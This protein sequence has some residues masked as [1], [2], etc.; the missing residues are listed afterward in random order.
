MPGIPEE[1]VKTGSSSVVVVGFLLAGCAGMM[2]D[3]KEVDEKASDVV[4]SPGGEIALG[5]PNVKIIEDEADAKR[6]AALLKQEMKASLAEKKIKVV[7]SSETK[8]SITLTNYE[9]GCGFCRG[10]FPLFG[11]GDSAVDGKVELISAGRRRVLVVQKTGQMT[12]TSQMGDQ[13]DTNV[14]YFSTVVADRLTEVAKD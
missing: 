11:L 8:L 14:E 10:F 4:L 13:T 12:G 1:I 7:D 6:V 5:E 9:T 3:V 2:M